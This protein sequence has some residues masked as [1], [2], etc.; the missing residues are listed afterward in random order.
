MT[1][2]RRVTCLISGHQ[3]VTR[4]SRHHLTNHTSE[5]SCCRELDTGCKCNYS[6][7]HCLAG[8]KFS[9]SCCLS[10]HTWD[11]QWKEKF[12]LHAAFN[13]NFCVSFD[14]M[15]VDTCLLK[16]VVH[17]RSLWR[18]RGDDACTH[19]IHSMNA[20]CRW[21]W[22]DDGAKDV[23][24]RPTSQLVSHVWLVFLPQGLL[25]TSV[26]LVRAPTQHCVKT[27]HWLMGPPEVVV[28]RYSLFAV[29]SSTYNH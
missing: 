10:Y 17:L 5:I 12:M 1:R 9:G 23:T 22:R 2:C 26:M 11:V 20:T 4:E 8:T 3:S 25:Q 29:I 6:V 15:K 24:V 27:R 28:R 14:V 19:W 13:H 21:T 18:Q 16:T 7:Y